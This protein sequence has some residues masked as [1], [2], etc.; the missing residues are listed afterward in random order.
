MAAVILYPQAGLLSV[1]HGMQYFNMLSLKYILGTGL[2]DGVGCGR[3]MFYQQV[4]NTNHHT[5][6]VVVNTDGCR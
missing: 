2:E 1:M 6:A 5:I 3:R 4:I